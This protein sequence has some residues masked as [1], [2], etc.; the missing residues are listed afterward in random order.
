MTSIIFCT[1]ASLVTST[2]CPDSNDSCVRA[3][4]FKA[5]NSS[6]LRNVTATVAPSCRK[7]RLT[8]RPR[9]P[10]PPATKASLFENRLAIVIAPLMIIRYSA[11]DWDMAVSNFD[12]KFGPQFLDSVPGSPGV[13]LI[14]DEK[15]E[16]IY[17][18]KAKH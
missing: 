3:D 6:C 2:W 15:D 12:R 9:P 8:A 13:Y 1:S 10:V 16:L 7:A 11:C 17:V 5:S 14:Y 18:G 4:C